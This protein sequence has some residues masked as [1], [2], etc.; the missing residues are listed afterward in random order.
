MSYEEEGTCHM[1]RRI[2]KKGLAYKRFSAVQ[3]PKARGF[4][5]ILVEESFCAGTRIFEYYANL[6]CTVVVGAL[7]ELSDAVR[8]GA[9]RC[10]GEHRS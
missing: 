5:G 2:H 4:K 10:G 3:M 8:D 6:G 9:E 1:R 7:A